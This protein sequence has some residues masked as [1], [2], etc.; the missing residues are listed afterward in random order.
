M[1]IKSLQNPLGR[2]VTFEG[3]E[4]SGK[5]TQIERAAAFLRGQ[6]RDV[7]IT[8]EPGGSPGAEALRHILLSGQARGLGLEMEAMLFA[9]ARADHVATRIRPALREGR[10]VLCDRFHDSTRVYQGQS[11]VERPLLDLLEEAALQGVAPVLTFVLDL[12]A[13]DGLARAASRRGEGLVDRFEGEALELHER[14]RQAFLD[15][16]QAEPQRCHVIDASRS[17]EAV[18]AS[19]RTILAE[20]LGVTAP[21]AEGAQ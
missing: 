12:P 14:R 4:G 18:A 7:L 19:I 21:P 8:R 5:S 2:F 10:D 13:E 16:A 15:L 11:G 9:A 6:G 20:R 1:S 3:G 17:V